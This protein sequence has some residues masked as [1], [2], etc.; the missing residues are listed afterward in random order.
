MRGFCNEN[1]WSCLLHGTSK[2]P[3]VVVTE[4]S[5]ALRKKL[6]P[7]HTLVYAL[8]SCFSRPRQSNPRLPLEILKFKSSMTA[9]S[10]CR[11]TF[12]AAVH[13]PLDGCNGGRGQAL[14]LWTQIILGSGDDESRMVFRLDAVHA[15]P[16]LHLKWQLRPK[17]L[18][19]RLHAR[20]YIRD[21]QGGYI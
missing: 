5:L 20:V 12:S 21:M 11:V 1:G 3:N 4:Y 18:P 15:C 9:K 8:H 2:F 19:E 16:H 14:W 17:S 7:Y 6:V 13:K 10:C